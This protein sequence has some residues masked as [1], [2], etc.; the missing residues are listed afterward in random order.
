MLKNYLDRL[1]HTSLKDEKIE[2]L[3]VDVTGQTTYLYYDHSGKLHLIFKSEESITENRNGIK[4]RNTSLDIVGFGKHSFIDIVCTLE[5]FKIEFIKIMDEI[6]EH[7]KQHN[8]LVK[9]IKITI[10]K[11]YYFFDKD[12]DTELS[13]AQV[14][15]L[16]GEL[17]F[18]KNSSETHSYKTITDAW[19]GP[20]SGLR[21]FNF[22][23]FDVEV[24][25]S[26]KEVGHVHTINGQIQL[27]SESIP[28]YVYSVSLKKSDSSNSI[29]LKTLIDDICLAIGEDAF[30]L[31]EFYQK[32]E[33]L[34]VLVTKAH[35]YDHFSYELRNTLTIKI[36]NENLNEFLV[37]NTNTRISNLKYD[38]DFNGLPNTEIE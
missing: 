7:F 18:I 8:D 23:T 2:A 36:D 6:I 13:E 29:T 10:N 21:D 5:N 9:A 15:G 34:N 26:S 28:L 31:N 32:L 16:L 33:N 35:I 22:N 11:W 38:Y 25:T 37:V 3:E 17:L 27:H 4:V 24:K 30:L 14:K 1:K 12:N 20:E 19:K